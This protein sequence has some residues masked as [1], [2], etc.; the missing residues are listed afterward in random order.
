M[1]REP[2]EQ[3]INMSVVTCGEAILVGLQK[4]F[5]GIELVDD[6]RFLSQQ[7]NPCLRRTVH[8][9]FLLPFHGCQVIRNGCN[10]VVSR[11]SLIVDG[12]GLRVVRHPL[13]GVLQSVQNV[14]SGGLV[15]CLAKLLHVPV[16]RLTMIP[17]NSGNH[18]TRQVEVC[19]ISTRR[20]DFFDATNL[21][22]H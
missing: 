18:A 6:Q 8:N 12:G 3:L 13:I 21:P 4:F 7:S 11:Q 5:K 16:R 15:F 14:L 17:A 2:R 20:H 10:E 1:S 22:E 19:C 9:Q